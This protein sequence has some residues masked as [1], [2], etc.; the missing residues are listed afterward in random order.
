MLVWGEVMKLGLFYL[1]VIFWLVAENLHAQRTIK[2]P[3]GVVMECKGKGQLIRGKKTLTIRRGMALLENDSLVIPEKGA[4]I[5]LDSLDGLSFF[6]ESG[7]FRVKKK[8]DSNNAFS[9]RF[10]REWLSARKWLEGARGKKKTTRR[11]ADEWIRLISP[12]N[13]RLLA[14]P[15][16]LAWEFLKKKETAE[17][18]IRCYDNDFTFQQQIS[19][20]S[21]T[22]DIEIEAG[23]QY[24][25]TV[26][27]AAAGIASAAT[28]VWFAVLSDKEKNQFESD[29]RLL[30]DILKNE[31][32]SVAARLLHAN[33]YLQYGLLQEASDQLNA[34]LAIEPDN[35]VAL[36]FYARIY[37]QLDFPDETRRY[38]ELT[39]KYDP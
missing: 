7:R 2:N 37:E 29:L 25:W 12:R 30:R 11:S 5:A 14:P 9:G 22:P 8:A 35:T 4:V 24:Y 33:L 39:D 31:T 36:L 28:E 32:N 10:F 38:I 18:V 27:F 17:I 23:L 26:Q 6:S 13:T 16:S 21:Y 15:S 3:A 1:F 34:A 19:G 20:T